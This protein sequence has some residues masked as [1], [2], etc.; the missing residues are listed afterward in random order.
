MWT[1]AATV[2]ATTPAAMKTAT[3]GRRWALR[4]RSAIARTAESAESIG[5]RG[6]ARRR[7]TPVIHDRRAD[8]HRL[9]ALRSG[10][11]LEASALL[12]Q[13]MKPARRRGSRHLG[14][15]ALRIIQPSPAAALRA[16]AA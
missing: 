10:S 2:T 13:R 3:R 4:R 14:P 11:R 8:P 15:R 6:R 9:R 16:A 5:G 7:F 1:A 12:R